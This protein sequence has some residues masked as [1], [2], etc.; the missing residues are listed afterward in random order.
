LVHRWVPDLPF[1]CRYFRDQPLTHP[2]VTEQHLV[3][4]YF[5]DW[6][7]KYFFAILQL[8]EVLLFTLYQLKRF[9]DIPTTQAL[10][11]DPLPY[12]RTQAM[13]LIFQ[14]LR[15]KPEQE[16]N[17][18]RLLINKLVWLFLTCMHHLK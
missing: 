11:V 17:L 16:Q 13:N 10:S 7:K 18:L 8:L 15:D 3:L 14:L 12:V 5:E 4:W 6:L 1:G 9:L 2:D